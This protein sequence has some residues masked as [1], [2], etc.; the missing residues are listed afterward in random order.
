MVPP[1]GP[2]ESVLSPA[3]AVDLTPL[4][5]T[6]LDLD[7][8]AADAPAD[9]GSAL[10]HASEGDSDVALDS[11][12]WAQPDDG[13]GDDSPADVQHLS[14]RPPRVRQRSRKRELFC[15]AHPQQR[16]EGNGQKYFLHLLT[17]EELKAR[18][19]SD[20]KA[21]LVINA[22]PVLVLTN[23]WLEELFC[24][25]CGGNRWCHVVKHDRVNHT[26]RW[27]PRELWEQVAH[28]DPIVANPTVSEYTR[29]ESR[30]H[31]RKRSD[32]RTYFD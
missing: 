24:P 3:E 31:S 27:A 7:D 29:R 25:K 30:R 12:A 2:S 10:P 5:L 20:K 26:V 22:Y 14:A 1:L 11:A 18:G 17:P 16:V 32:G 4:D 28:V 21:Q 6:P 9:Q 15:P 13:L 19:M 23:E 8:R